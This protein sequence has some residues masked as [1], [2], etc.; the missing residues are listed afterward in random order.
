MTMA[1]VKAAMVSTTAAT[2][3]TGMTLSDYSNKHDCACTCICVCMRACVHMCVYVCV[4]L[5]IV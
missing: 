1:D 2:N 4:Q 5:V 3:G